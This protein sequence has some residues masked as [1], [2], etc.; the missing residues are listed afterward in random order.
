MS[1]G[2]SDVSMTPNTNYFYLWRHQDTSNNLCLKKLICGNLNLLDIR[3]SF[4]RERGATKNQE[5]PSYK[6]LEILN[7]RA[8]SSN[9]KHEIDLFEILGYVI[10]IYRTNMK[11]KFGNRGSISLQNMKWQVDIKYGI[12]IFQQRSKY[13]FKTLKR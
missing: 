6:F 12:N 13:I 11:W 3:I 9:K 8:I 5:G 2:F 4:F 10:S 7:T 1:L